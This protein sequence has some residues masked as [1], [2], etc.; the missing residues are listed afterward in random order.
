MRLLKP[1]ARD[2]YS[3][4][5]SGQL[6]SGAMRSRA[7]AFCA[8]LLLAC[9][10]ALQPG[11]PPV[12]RRVPALLPAR[13]R[14]SFVQQS[15]D[16]RPS[17]LSGT[18]ISFLRWYKQTISP[19]LPPGCRYVPTCSE[20][21]MQAFKEF[22]VPQATVL[23]A[24]RLVRC[25][26]LHLKG[27]GYGVDVP[28]WPPP[29]YWAGSGRVRNLLDDEASRR[30]AL[31]LEDPDAGLDPFALLLERAEAEAST[32]EEEAAPPPPRQ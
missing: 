27:Y 8:L 9:T 21:A 2:G 31:S 7:H 18:A 28:C 6:C 17:G 1:D 32:D 26:P 4:C 5:L 25:N 22:S 23:T 14:R 15:E 29:A 12:R 13:R 3:V 30:K 20:Y 24:W 19:L 16:G 10:C 11:P